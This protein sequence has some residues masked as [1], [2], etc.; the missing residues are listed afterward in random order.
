MP[1]NR[2]DNNGDGYSHLLYLALAFTLDKRPVLPT[3][4]YPFAFCKVTTQKQVSF[5]TPNLLALILG[6][7][8]D[9]SANYSA[10]S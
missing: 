6:R 5:H 3:F 8:A 1:V 7:S 10:L 4:N 9:P 2:H